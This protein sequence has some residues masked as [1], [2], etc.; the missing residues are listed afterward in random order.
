MDPKSL[1]PN[2]LIFDTAQ[3]AAEACG[4]DTLKL[5]EQARA[6]RLVATLAVSG[7]NTP[8]VMFQWMAKQSFD[9]TS[10]HIF[11]VDERCVPPDHELSN[12][13]MTKAALLDAIKIDA[14]QVH[15]IQGELPPDE[16][17]HLYVED[18]RRI[19]KLGAGELPA[20]DV[21][22]RGMGPDGHTASLFPGGPLISNHTDIAAAVDVDKTYIDKAMRWRVTLLP[23]VLE[24]A[25]H[26]LNL[27]TG[28]DKADALH[29]V[30]RGPRD[31]FALPAQL[32]SPGTTWY[33]DQSL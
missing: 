8:K 23:G 28:P 33:T 18:I 32:D 26:T 11:Q 20:F 2:L 1:T 3:A 30:L 24:R 4:A 13:R 15:R 25:R 6:E 29:K 17:A 7:G 19:L 9:W 14:A 22:Q 12:F 27:V 5:L 10:I 21:I 16:A 31:L